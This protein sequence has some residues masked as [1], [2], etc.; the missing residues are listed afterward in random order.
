M[1]VPRSALPALLVVASLLAAAPGC[2]YIGPSAIGKGRMTY[3]EVINYTEDQQ[4]LNL[5][6]RERYHET[7]GMLRV[8]GITASVRARA[9][10]GVELGIFGSSSD[11]D[12]N[13][14]PLS[15]GVA[16]EENPTISYV[17]LSGEEYLVR[18]LTPLTI[19]QAVLLMQA[20]WEDELWMRELHKRINGIYNPV[21]GPASEELPVFLRAYRA[22]NKAGLVTMERHGGYGDTAPTYSVT[23]EA[24]PED[25]KPA[26]QDLITS[27]GL[28][29]IEVDGSSFTLPM[30]TGLRTW[31]TDSIR[32]EHRSAYDILR[33]AASMI[34]V[35]KEHRDSGLASEAGWNPG[36]GDRFIVIKSSK[37][38]PELA[39]VALQYRDYWYYID[40]AD[41]RSKA[42]F[43]I[44]RLLVGMRLEEAS[45][46]NEAP[47]ITVP[48]G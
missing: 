20:A 7:F 44:L 1:P 35:P 43:K 26:V 47:L 34:E 37:E 31:S 9:E 19:D 24:Y 21:G 30:R 46:R 27:L 11:Y 36:D 8:A 41:T 29:G 38:K 2:A 17:P 13:L 33:H 15:A 12:G 28:E 39:T 45:S 48:V 32:L 5:I 14:V 22:L 10:M 18:L 16:Y 4:L 42:S 25:L 23:V 6:V 3:N 40:A